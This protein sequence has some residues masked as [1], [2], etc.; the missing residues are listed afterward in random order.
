MADGFSHW[1][2]WNYFQSCF[3]PLARITIDF[4]RWRLFSPPQTADDSSHWWTSSYSR[5][6][7]FAGVAN[8]WLKALVLILPTTDSWWFFPLMDLKLLPSCYIPLA[9]R[10]IDCPRCRLFS[11][12]IT[13]DRSVQWW[14][15]SYFRVA[16]FRWSGEPSTAGIGASSPYHWRLVVLPTDELPSCFHILMHANK[17][18]CQLYF[19]YICMCFISIGCFWL[20]KIYLCLPESY[21]ALRL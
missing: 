19:I 1:R 8:N 12:P 13:V 18:P 16:I 21:W 5:V 2:T 7:I 15:S 10:T 14:T 11:P 4:R 20:G 9:Q 17:N 6:T 3:D